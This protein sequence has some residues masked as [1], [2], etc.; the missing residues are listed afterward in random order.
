M[1]VTYGRGVGVGGEWCVY[2]HVEV[3]LWLCVVGAGG[4]LSTVQDL[5]VIGSLPRHNLRK[6]KEV[7]SLG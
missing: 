1:G 2:L 7:V 3:R 6:E 4:C 5:H